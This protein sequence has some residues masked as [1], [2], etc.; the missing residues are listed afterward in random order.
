MPLIGLIGGTTWHST[1]EYYR[2]FNELTWNQ[3]D[4][5]DFA[6]LLINSLNFCEL[7]RNNE[8]GTPEKN[9]DILIE[10]GQQLKNGG[11]THLMI[12]ANTL[13][14]WA[15][16]LEE[17]VGIPLI[18]LLTATAEAIRAQNHRRV[19]LLGTRY[20]MEQ[21]FY[22]AAMAKHDIEILVPPE[23][24]RD[25]I[26]QTIYEDFAA[27]LFTPEA[28]FSYRLII[29]ELA[30]QGAEGVILGCTEIPILLAPHEIPIPSYDTTVIHVEAALRT[31]AK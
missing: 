3:T 16:D 15:D 5:H 24:V 23:G 14:Q 25:Y 9:R 20:T 12:G 10:A 22:Q 18:N 19:G 4:G 30:A 28:K 13:H 21:G 8:A 2:L 11:A 6:R 27:G 29:D 26:H 7:K 17:A 1:A 31:N